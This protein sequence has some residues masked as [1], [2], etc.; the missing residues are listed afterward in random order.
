M[1]NLLQSIGRTPLDGRVDAFMM[2]VGTGGSFSGK[3]A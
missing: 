3:I 1:R 2:G